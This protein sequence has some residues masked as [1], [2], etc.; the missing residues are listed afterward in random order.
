MASQWGK[1]PMKDV[2]L[3]A[4]KPSRFDTP[5]H[6]CSV[7]AE[8]VN[9]SLPT[10]P[11]LP[12][13]LAAIKPIYAPYESTMLDLR[14]KIFTLLDNHVPDMEV[15]MNLKRIVEYSFR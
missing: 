1:P 10:T 15:L 7:S 14:L 9:S 2:G 8:Q 13:V 6:M 4:H 3:V 5:E 12:S 11:D